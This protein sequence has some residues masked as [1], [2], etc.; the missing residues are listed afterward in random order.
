MGGGGWGGSFPETEPWPACCEYNGG[1]AVG[2]PQFSRFTP[3]SQARLE[4]LLADDH[5]H[6]DKEEQVFEAISRWLAARPSPVDERTI[7]ALLQH[8]RFPCMEYDYIQTHVQELPMMQSAAA[9]KVR[10][11]G[12]GGGGGVEERASG[13]EAMGS[14]WEGG[15]EGVGARRLDACVC[16]LGWGMPAGAAAAP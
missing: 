14:E 9:M 8:A 3:R 6:V 13:C 11:V 16:V 2:R 15:C 5:L 10:G 4:Q 1:E 12:G 7:V